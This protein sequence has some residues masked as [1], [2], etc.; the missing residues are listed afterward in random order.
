M[1]MI[2]KAEV[3]AL[4]EGFNLTPLPERLKGL[5]G[6]TVQAAFHHGSIR[7]VLLTD[8]GLVVL[9]SSDGTLDVGGSFRPEFMDPWDLVEA[10]LLP[11]QRYNEIRAG[12][13]AKSVAH[14]EAQR[15]R[16]YE[17]LKKEFEK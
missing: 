13:V 17:A 5:V 7:V 15:R 9:E 8:K 1:S 12:W 3:D 16:Q 2:E 11:E 14:Q 10:G 6:A 4:F